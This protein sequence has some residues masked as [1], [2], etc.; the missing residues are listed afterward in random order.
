MDIRDSRSNNN[1]NNS[2]SSKKKINCWSNA[3]LE[4]ILVNQSR[5]L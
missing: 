3:G 4:G 1:N 2:Q 5:L